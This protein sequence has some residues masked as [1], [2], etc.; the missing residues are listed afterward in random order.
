MAI[1]TAFYTMIKMQASNAFKMY[2]ASSEPGTTS[3]SSE[4]LLWSTHLSPLSRQPGLTSVFPFP[5]RWQTTDGFTN[6][7]ETLLF[8][9]SKSVL[10]HLVSTPGPPE[11]PAQMQILSQQVRGATTSPLASG[12]RGR[13]Q[14]P[15][16]PSLRGQHWPAPL[17]RVE[18]PA[19]GPGERAELG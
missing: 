18:Q 14:S 7:L 9:S 2:S 6:V 4:S 3:V 17:L 11:P 8:A 19:P 1:H 15:H 12:R 16:V 5:E 13:Q 10:P